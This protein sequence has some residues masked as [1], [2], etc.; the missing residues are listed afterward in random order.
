MKNP[1]KGMTIGKNRPRVA[2]AFEDA[3]QV[4]VC[5]AALQHILGRRSKELAIGGGRVG[6]GVR[7]V[8]PQGTT[9]MPVLEFHRSEK[10]A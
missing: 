4:P 5:V 1:G 7:A 6:D 8:G 9:R 3:Q 10:A 2:V